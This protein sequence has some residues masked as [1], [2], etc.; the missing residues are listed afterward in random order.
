ML[1]VVLLATLAL[2]AVTAPA[3]SAATLVVSD[4]LPDS[5]V[6]FVSEP[7][8]A[9][10]VVVA[11][12]GSSNVS[13]SGLASRLQTQ[14]V[15]LDADDVRF[16]GPLSTTGTH[17]LTVARGGAVF[18]STLTV[19]GLL[20]LRG[21]TAVGG[22][23]DAGSVVAG[24]IDAPS[25]ELDDDL[26]LVA[27]SGLVAA[28]VPDVVLADV[29]GAG[30]LTVGG[31]LV[32]LGRP[33]ASAS[34]RIGGLTTTAGTVA[35]LADDVHTSGP[36]AFG[37][38]VRL[39]APFLV[40]DPNGEDVTFGGT[41]DGATA[42]DVGWA[43]TVRFDGALGDVT[44]LTS[45][46]MLATS[47]VTLPPR[48][49]ATGAL[50]FDGQP[51]L[52]GDAS[53]VA[54][55]A[56]TV[57]GPAFALGGHTLTSSAGGGTTLGAAPAGTGRIVLQGAGTS[58]IAPSAMGPA[59]DPVPVVADGSTVVAMTAPAS[60]LPYAVRGGGVL[61]GVGALGSVSAES[62]GGVLDP[63][64]LPFGSALGTLPVA[65][66]SLSPSVTVR[67]DAFAGGLD[68]LTVS[69]PVALDG[70]A[71]DLRSAALALPAVGSSR[72]IIEK[73]SAGPVTGTFSGLPEGGVVRS[74]GP[75]LRVSYTG[76]DGNDV[77]V[78]R[79]APASLTLTAAV[80][81]DEVELR[82]TLAP[83]TATGAV[84]FRTTSGTALGSAAVGPDGTA[85]LRTSALA[86]GTHEVV[87][88][89]AGD[90]LT[91]SAAS[92]STTVRVPAPPTPDPP[93]TPVP[94]STPMPPSTPTAPAPAAPAAATPATAPPAP[95]AAAVGTGLRTLSKPT[96]H[97][98]RLTVRQRFLTPG[99]VTWQLALSS[100]KPRAAS[101]APPTVLA[102]AR[103][104]IAAP[105]EAT[106]TFPLD[107]RARAL[108]RRH[109]RS[110]L[111]LRTTFTAA[112]GT[113]H[114]SRRTLALTPSAALSR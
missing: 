53:L 61:A 30:A 27:T 104:T 55:G 78:T 83:P 106:A 99:R 105:G 98:R 54:G 36:V 96:V 62:G 4:V 56:V 31:P 65:S 114:R 44:P 40:V 95:A 1:R 111:V 7:G 28:G 29:S 75:P 68:E 50:Q 66:L 77:T 5:N 76:G 112:D 38:P 42:L 13:A 45:L 37:G 39:A 85:T 97:A 24:A 89:Y 60:A 74:S 80:V 6:S 69:G 33:G 41:V 72:T 64:A 49:H 11:A 3:A 108:L 88:E 21:A 25:V 46:G 70:A 110:R 57:T 94:P 8:G 84:T 23:G 63:G 47:T 14:D 16:A 79:I 93:S 87:A 103:A 10:R 92:T 20:D 43:R 26:S 48:A 35:R 107:A 58:R 2:C 12:P 109:R 86:P 51:A 67:L 102:T 91:D 22:D 81:D 101:A 15:V 113:V 17:T 59:P 73:A 9:V 19:G 82:A 32:E 18:E 71:L 90:P 52:A 34:S 100:W